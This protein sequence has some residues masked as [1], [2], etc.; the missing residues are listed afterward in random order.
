MLTNCRKPGVWSMTRNQLIPP[1]ATVRAGGVN[2]VCARQFTA[3]MN[4]MFGPQMS[5]DLGGVDG[6][7]QAFAIAGREIAGIKGACPQGIKDRGYACGGNLR[8]MGNDC[9][10]GGPLDPGAWMKMTFEMIG[11][12]FN[13]AGDQIVAIKIVKFW[14]LATVD[15]HDLAILHCQGTCDHF[16][17]EHDRRIGEHQPAHDAI[18]HLTL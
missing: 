4:E 17:G 6:R 18:L 9:R 3:Q 16:V 1:S 15:C 12:K 11:V 2:R 8:I 13:Q 10:N 5:V 14:R 7:C